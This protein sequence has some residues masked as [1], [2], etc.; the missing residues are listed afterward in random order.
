L[1][2]GGLIRERPLHERRLA[3]LGYR[4]LRTVAAKAGLDLL[5]RTFY[6]P[7]PHL[8]ELQPGTFDRV[9]DLPGVRWNLD[10][11]IRFVKEQL[12]QPMAEFRPP[13][14]E[15]EGSQ[16]YAAHNP[17]Y[18]LLDATVAYG[19]VRWLRPRLI[20]ELGSGH[21]TLV[22]AQAG[23]R[24]QSEGNPFR[25]EVFDPF[26]S[27]MTEGLPG[28][29]A[30]HRTPAQEVPVTVFEELGD[31]DVLFVD[32]THTVK[33]GSEVNVV[34]LEVLPRLR[35]GVVV[36]FHDIFLPFEYPRRWMEDFALYWNEQYLIQAFLAHNESWEVLVAA[37][38]LSRMRRQELTD[39]VGPAVAGYDA[40]SFW[41]RRNVKSAD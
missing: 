9:S 31:G 33:I 21:S 7:V 39:L 29:H 34:V 6:S 1:R 18:S 28:L 40:A 37:Q 13:A 25:L 32:T 5:L 14:T 12:A 19:M 23:M 2:L 20:V 36:H 38:A 8:D 4:G 30:L 35:P 24:N 15:P 22:T 26:P 3:I 41:M 10:S 16:A 11:Q 27:A 17:S